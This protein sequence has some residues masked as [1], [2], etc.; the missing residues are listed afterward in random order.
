MVC[1]GAGKLS[2]ALRK[3]S[4]NQWGVLKTKAADAI[5]AGALKY[6]CVECVWVCVRSW[7]VYEFNSACLC[8]NIDTNCL[9]N[10]VDMDE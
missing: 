4:A 1:L 3:R 9:L 7:Q 2:G 8:I 6:G 5:T 10:F